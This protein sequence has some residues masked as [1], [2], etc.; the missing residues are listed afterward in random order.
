MY[1]SNKP[2]QQ[3]QQTVICA[4]Y[5]GNKVKP[6]SMGKAIPGYNVKVLFFYVFYGL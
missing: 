2:Q 5:N 3:R 6:G 4:N 1:I